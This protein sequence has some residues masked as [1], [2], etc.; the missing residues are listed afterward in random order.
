MVVLKI[1]DR[2]VLRE[3]VLPFFIGLLVL[4]F[5]L[6]IPVILRDAEQL[7]S[8][9]VEWSIVVR[10]LLT[11]LPQALALTI[12]MAILF[13]LLIGLGRLSGDREFVALQACGIS[14]FRLLSPVALL[15]VTGAAV[16]AYVMIVSLPN[17]NQAFREI[18]AGLVATRAEHNIKPHVFF[19]DFPNRVVYVRDAPLSGGWRDVFLADSTA[20]S[21]TDVYVAKEGRLI[22][23]RDRHTVQLQLKDGI[24][25]TTNVS[26]PEEYQ[27]A[28]F[29]DTTLS[30]DP[31][32]V[33]PRP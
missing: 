2:Y 16:T 14:L 7:I 3:I 33:F 23:D 18:T 5:I 28:K 32:I 15:A 4:T 22:V 19:D 9:G 27:V 24:Q 13:G 30:L 11:L 31:G 17:A 12:P 21:H 8:K 1:L 6:E 10:V 25:H 26:K 20:A 29:G